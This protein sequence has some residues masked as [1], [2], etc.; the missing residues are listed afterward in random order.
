MRNRI[1]LHL[2]ALLLAPSVATLASSSV[3]PSAKEDLYV[4]SSC[5]RKEAKQLLFNGY[6]GKWYT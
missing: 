4:P 3:A 6:H 1:V 2:A 5:D